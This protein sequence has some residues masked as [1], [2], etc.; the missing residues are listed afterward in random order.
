VYVL[1]DVGGFQSAVGLVKVA[2]V[3]VTT[4]VSAASTTVIVN[5]F[6]ITLEVHASLSA[7]EPLIISAVTAVCAPLVYVP[8]IS[9][10]MV[11]IA[12]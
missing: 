3:P 1:L 12:I 9:V 8:V 2:V 4:R 11:R 7:L 6:P 5:A 10:S